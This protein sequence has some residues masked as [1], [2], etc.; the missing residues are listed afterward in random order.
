MLFRSPDL[1]HALRRPLGQ[2]SLGNLLD[3][4][5]EGNLGRSHLAAATWLCY[6]AYLHLRKAKPGEWRDACV[7]LLISFVCLQICWWGINYLPSAKGLSV[8]TY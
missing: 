6:L 5:P 3:L 2:R 8:H 1:R 4:G 7:I